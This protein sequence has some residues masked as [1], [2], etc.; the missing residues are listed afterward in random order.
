[1]LKMN[2]QLFAEDDAIM[3]DDF[4]DTP[5]EELTDTIDLEETTEVEDITPTEE[6]TT[7]VTNEQK[8]KIK[9]NHE[10]KEISL[11]EAREL[12]Q[13]GMAFD[14]SIERARQEARDAVISEQGYTWNG[15]P[16]KT[17]AEYKQALSEQE[18]IN[19]Y[20]DA[21]L[22]EEVIKELV[23]G[24]KDR[25]D[26]QAEQQTKETTA[27][28]DADLRDFVQ[29]FPDVQADTIKPETWDKVNSGVPLKYAYMEQERADLLIQAKV[30]QQNQKNRERAPVASVS[31]HGTGE[32]N[33]DAFLEGFDS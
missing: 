33:S 20:K 23:A 9:F 16:I 5:T 1:M 21:N 10:E 13:K 14:K 17:E 18:L 30:G 12:A 3:P 31:A 24:K 27:K 26:R 19:K 7:P 15:Q 25:E 11:E 8:L 28:A 2:L 29:A 22:P 6:V 32:V 4:E